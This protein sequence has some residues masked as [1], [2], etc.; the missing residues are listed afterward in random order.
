MNA[1]DMPLIETCSIRAEGIPC[2]GPLLADDAP[3]TALST[4]QVQ[5]ALSAMG[6]RRMRV[7]DAV[8]AVLT[9]HRRRLAARER[10]W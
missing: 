7:G 4:C 9:F 10:A 6:E 2:I 3:P 8:I 5:R 1:L